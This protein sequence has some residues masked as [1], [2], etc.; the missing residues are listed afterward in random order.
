MCRKKLPQYSI[1]ATQICGF[2][3]VLT[4]LSSSAIISPL[5]HSPQKEY[6]VSSCSLAVCP[7]NCSGGCL[8]SLIGFPL[9]VHF[10]GSPASLPNH[11]ENH[12][13]LSKWTWAWWSSLAFL[14]LVAFFGCCSCSAAS[15]VWL[16][17]EPSYLERIEENPVEELPLEILEEEPLEE[18]PWRSHYLWWCHLWS[19]LGGVRGGAS[20]RGPP[21]AVAPMEILEE[22]P[23]VELPAE[24]P[25]TASRPRPRQL[26]SWLQAAVVVPAMMEVLR[27]NGA[28]ISFV[29]C[30]QCLQQGGCI[31]PDG[32]GC[33]LHHQAAPQ[34]REDHLWRDSPFEEGPD[35]AFL[36]LHS[37]WVCDEPILRV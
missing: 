15:P 28:M 20:L 13:I 35:G 5:H 34:D 12:L 26:A 21:M 8:R 33:F 37:H 32:A 31:F 4:S 11:C 23:M 10:S 36:L 19:S 14:A 2:T 16:P 24:Q 17:W 3:E 18:L 9:S 27:L 30:D 29:A 7:F 22:E 1:A 25:T 6:V